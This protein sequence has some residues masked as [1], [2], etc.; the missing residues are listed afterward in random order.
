MSNGRDLECP[1][2]PDVEPAAADIRHA[3]ASQDFIRAQDGHFKLAMARPHVEEV[4]TD[5]P[6]EPL[7]LV[8]HTLDELARCRLVH[9]TSSYAHGRLVRA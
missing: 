7:P 6:I 4:D 1:A 3:L 2:E 8:A 5:T 9:Q